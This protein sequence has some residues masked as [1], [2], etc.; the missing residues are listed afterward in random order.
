[1]P[2]RKPA[3]SIL[4]ARRRIVRWHSGS[5]FQSTVDAVATEEPLEIQVETRPISV[6]MRTPGHDE[7]LAAGFLLSEGV[8]E[9]REQINAIRPYPRNPH[10]NAVN[11]FLADGVTIDLA[12]LTR[13][14]FASSSCGLCGKASI[15]AVHRQ[16]QPL[17]SDLQ[18]TASQLPSLGTQMRAAQK[19]FDETGGLHAAALF[20]ETGALSVLREDVGRH[21]AMDK[22]LGHALLQGWLPLNRHIAF[23]SGRA[24]FELVQKVLAARI[25]IL[26]AVSAP[27][28][29][30]IDLARASKLT[31][32]GFVRDGRFNVYS[33]THRIV[34]S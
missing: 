1:M 2:A 22:V 21:N 30:A 20:D 31:L 15:Q 13:H 14:V 27:S 34:P 17:Q 8:I 26:C 25:P 7:E 10:G 6:T 4:H 3:P 33:G 12:R 11:V 16:F 5:D 18:L 28:S 32:V 19:A 23:V 24:S 9:S 29:L